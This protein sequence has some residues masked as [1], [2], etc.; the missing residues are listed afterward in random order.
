MGARKGNNKPAERWLVITPD[1]GVIIVDDLKAWCKLRAR[2]FRP[3]R[4]ENVHSKLC[5]R[6]RRHGDWIARPIK[7][8]NALVLGGGEILLLPNKATTRARPIKFRTRN[9]V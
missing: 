4:W 2:D 8:I 1:R 9:G 7:N 6:A 3:S 5:S